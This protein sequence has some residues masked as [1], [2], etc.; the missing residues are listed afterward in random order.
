[1]PQKATNEAL[2][3]EVERVV[4]KSA[5]YSA[6]VKSLESSVEWETWLRL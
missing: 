3:A 2:K 6:T 1:M 5:D 4:I